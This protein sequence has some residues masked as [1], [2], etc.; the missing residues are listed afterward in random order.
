MHAWADLLDFSAKSPL[1]E[2]FTPYRNSVIIAFCSTAL[3][4][5]IGAMAAYALARIEY[6][7]KLGTILIFVV[8]MIAAAVAVGVQGVDL[9][10]AAAVAAALFIL[11]ARSVG[12]HFKRSLGNADILFWMISQRILP[13]VVAV[14]P[15]YMMFQSVRMLDTHLAIILTYTVINLR[16]PSG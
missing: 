8:L 16:S 5:L 12:R 13:P 11:L 15:I 10:L 14:V 6:K 9:W 4:V 3:C 7:P 1:A 2:T